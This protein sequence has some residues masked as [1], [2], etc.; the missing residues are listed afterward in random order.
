MTDLLN[1]LKPFSKLEHLLN[2]LYVLVNYSE[3]SNS[4][5]TNLINKLTNQ[6][7]TNSEIEDL[8]KRL[9]NFPELYGKNF[10]NTNLKETID[11]ILVEETLVNFKSDA[12]VCEFCNSK[13]T[14]K[15]KDFSAVCYFYSSKPKKA[16]IQ[17]KSCQ[18]CGAVHYLSYA[19]KINTSDY[20]RKM[21]KNVLD[22]KYVAFTNETIFERLLLDSFT[23]DLIYKYSSFM[24]FTSAYNFLFG[25]KQ[26]Y[27]NDNDKVKR[28]CLNEKR[29]IDAWF[30]YQ[31]LKCFNEIN[32]SFVMCQAPQMTNL[33]NT[34]RNLK[35][36]LL[37]FFVQKWSG[38]KLFLVGII[39]Y[40]MQK[41]KFLN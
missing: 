39:F 19:E 9:E 35:P 5:L 21:L 17:T 38:N 23:S 25:C 20:D 31:F 32:K 34:I 12:L 40:L 10:F 6:N 3:H 30:Y 29:L 1:L 11:S 27:L 18:L 14:G 24:G 37:K 16:T 7:K 36:S 22:A 28:S 41:L 13:L 8:N 4:T 26:D 33:N 2:A 15:R